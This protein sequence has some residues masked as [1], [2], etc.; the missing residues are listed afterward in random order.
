MLS[1]H[2]EALAAQFGQYADTGM[3]LERQAVQAVVAVLKGMAEQA[4]ALEGTI[5]P[6]AA[7]RSVRE[8]SGNLVSLDLARERRGRP[9]RRSPGD[10]A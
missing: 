2:L 9:P 5:V 6:P 3:E 8:E 10:A 7:R 4:G 1:A